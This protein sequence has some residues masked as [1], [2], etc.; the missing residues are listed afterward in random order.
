M[1]ILQSTL[2]EIN[3]AL[4]A[5]TLNLEPPPSCAFFLLYPFNIDVNVIIQNPPHHWNVIIW[6]LTSSHDAPVMSCSFWQECLHMHLEG[7]LSRSPCLEWRCWSRCSYSCFLEQ[8]NVAH[9]CI[10]WHSL[11]GTSTCP[12]VK[13]AR[14]Q[15]IVHIKKINYRWLTY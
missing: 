13:P 3:L 7:M 15:F 5:K 11:P 4:L 10:L 8:D 1:G 14:I 6:C 2:E 12:C 9:R